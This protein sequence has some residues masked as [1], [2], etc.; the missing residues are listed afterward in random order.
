VAARWR[1]WKPTLATLFADPARL[2][3][4]AATLDLPGGPIRFDWSKTHLSPAVEAVLADLARPRLPA[5]AK[6]LSGAKI[7]NTEGRAA[8]HT[9]QRGVGAE[10]SVEEAEALHAA[11]RCWSMRSTKACWA[12]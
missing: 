11:W 9:A 10:A 1:R 8:E 7:N 5:S 3:A 4:Y 2:D 12:R 6:L